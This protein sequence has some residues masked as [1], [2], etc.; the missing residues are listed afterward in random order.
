M[1]QSA[2]TSKSGSKLRIFSQHG[3]VAFIFITALL[4][5]VPS[6]VLVR[7]LTSSSSDDRPSHV[8]VDG[9]IGIQ[10][11]NA[12]SDN[13]GDDNKKVEE[14]R[15]LPPKHVKSPLKDGTHKKAEKSDET[16]QQLPP[17][18]QQF[19]SFPGFSN[20]RSVSCGMHTAKSC[21]LCPQGNG[22]GWCNGECE[23][24][25]GECVRS[26]KV[27]YIHP[28]YFQI[29]QRYAFQPVM[30]QNNE[31]VNVIA[32]RAPFRGKDDEEVYKF[33]KDDIL[34]LGI[35]SFEA[36]PLKSPNPYSGTFE[37]EYYLNMFPGF[38]HMLKEPNKHFPSNVET[39]LMS[40]SDFMLDQPMNFGQRHSNDEKIYDFVYSGGVSRYA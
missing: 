15:Q 19:K 28:D 8:R 10:K 2:L 29:T 38:L 20:S 21:D 33:Y 25:N 14:T 12:P 30:N 11:H 31:Y 7:N 22:A 16:A 13:A 35:S 34:F 32:V 1:P 27:E 24:R 37:S 4:L 39:I 9:V 26:S 17:P 5:L 36:Y 6:L 23:W 40:Q 3:F 18:K